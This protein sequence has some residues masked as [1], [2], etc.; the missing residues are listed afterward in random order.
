VGFTEAI[1]VGAVIIRDN[2]VLLLQRRLDDTFPGMW[3]LPSGKLEPGEPPRRGLRREVME[4]AGLLVTEACLVF[5]FEYTI[6]KDNTPSIVVQL[7]YRVAADDTPA[8]LSDEHQALAWVPRSQ[9]PN[10]SVS[11]ETCRAIHAA[12]TH[13]SGG[14][15]YR[16]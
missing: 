11:E 6:P 4:E 13:P 1:V 15:H 9:L 2:R 7:N 5:A 12:F 16:G 3:E 14:E 8:A 10:Y